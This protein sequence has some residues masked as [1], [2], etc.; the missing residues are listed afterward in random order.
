[1]TPLDHGIFR[2]DILSIHTIRGQ[3]GFDIL[4]SV[5]EPSE[6]SSVGSISRLNAAGWLRTIYKFSMTT[7]RRTQSAELMKLVTPHLFVE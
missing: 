4:F 2:E 3:S 6:A 5:G 1:M 7:C